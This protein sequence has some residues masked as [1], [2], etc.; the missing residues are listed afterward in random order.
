M[1]AVTAVI[2]GNARAGSSR[3]RSASLHDQLSTSL[4]RAGHNAVSLP[5]PAVATEA[6]AQRELTRHLDAGAERVYVLGGDG[7]VRSVA[8]LLLGRN[9]PLGIVPAGTANLLARDLGLPPEP[10]RAID[11]LAEAQVRRIDVGR[12]NGAIFLCAAMF[13]MTTDLA[14]AREAARGI[15]AWRMLPR[16][17]RRGYWLLKRYPF[18]RIRLHLDDEPVALTTRALL[19]SNNPLEPRAGLYP[20]RASLQGG[21]FGVY[22]VREGPLYDLPRLALTLL[23]GT[24]PDEPRVF[25]RSCR[26]LRIDTM[27]PERTTALLDGEREPLRAPLVFDLLPAALPVLA[28]A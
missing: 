26:R 12:C 25:H 28:P 2:I 1:G 23:A 13:G 10:E 22:G 3:D 5:F 27:R 24:W 20:S 21:R 14:R 15:G 7:T 11:A 16:L 19:V 9:M 8:A 17:L 6:R 18:H 4:A